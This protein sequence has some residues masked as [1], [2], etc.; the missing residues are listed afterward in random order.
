MSIPCEGAGFC[1]VIAF[2]IDIFCG[3]VFGAVPDKIEGFE[4]T[5]F[6]LHD[7]A[8]I[9]MDDGFIGN[10]PANEGKKR[11]QSFCGNALI[12]MPGKAFNRMNLFRFFMELIHDVSEQTAA[13]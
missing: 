2:F 6:R 3:C 1:H 9:D 4:F 10:P 7:V 13:G 8:V 11:F 12:Q 5:S